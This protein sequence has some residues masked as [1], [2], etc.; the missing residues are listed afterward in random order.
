MAKDL[1]EHLKVPFYLISNCL[2]LMYNL[3]LSAPQHCVMLLAK[4][5][6]QDREIAEAV[7]KLGQIGDDA[8][9]NYSQALKASEAVASSINQ[10]NALSLKRFKE[11][12]RSCKD[13]INLLDELQ[14]KINTSA[15]QLD[16]LRSNMEVLKQ[17]VTKGFASGK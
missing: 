10:T 12:E 7:Q 8:E 4:S 2:A 1:D 9:K 16:S 11:N 17:N 5:D 13:C 6:E 15:S 14:S 3:Q